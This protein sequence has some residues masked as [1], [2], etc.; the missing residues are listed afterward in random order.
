MSRRGDGLLRRQYLAA[1]RAGLSL[2][3]PVLRAGRSLA[4]NCFLSMSRRGDGLLR[5]QYLAA[6]RADLSVRQPVLRAGRCLAR[7]CFLGM[8]RRG[9]GL[10]RR[11]HLAAD[12]ADLS[13]RQSVLRAG[14]SLAGDCLLSV[15]HGRKPVFQHMPAL[16]AAVLRQSGLRA[17][18][19]HI[20]DPPGVML[21]ADIRVFRSVRGLRQFLCFRL[22]LR[23]QGISVFIEHID[24][25]ADPQRR[26]YGHLPG[27]QPGSGIGGVKPEPSVRRFLKA[28]MQHRRLRRS[29][30]ELTLSLHGRV[31]A[32]GQHRPVL[33]L[34]H[35]RD[36]LI[37][38]DQL[39]GHQN[40]G[41]VLRIT[42]GSVRF[43]ADRGAVQHP[44]CR[45]RIRR[46][47]Q[48]RLLL[49]QRGRID[50]NQHRLK[51][52]LL[53]LCER[54]GK[55]Q[56]NNCQ[57]NREC[58]LH[59]AFPPYHGRHVRVSA[60]TVPVDSFLRL[61]LLPDPFRQRESLRVNADDHKNDQG[62][63]RR[64]DEVCRQGPAGGC[65]SAGEQDRRAERHEHGAKYVSRFS[66]SPQSSYRTNQF[67]YA[68][69]D[70][71]R[72]SLVIISYLP[73]QKNPGGLNFPVGTD[74]PAE[75]V[76]VD[77]FFRFSPGLRNVKGLLRSGVPHER[78]GIPEAEQIQECVIK[79]ARAA[80]DVDPQ[81][82][83]RQ[84][85]VPGSLQDCRQHA[86]DDRKHAEGGQQGDQGSPAV[87]IDIRHAAVS[88]RRSNAEGE[89]PAGQ[90]L[91]GRA[92]RQLMQHQICQKPADKQQHAAHGRR[93]R[94]GFPRPEDQ[95]R[96]G[97]RHGQN[98]QAHEIQ[99]YAGFLVR[100][101]HGEYLPIPFGKLC[102]KM[103]HS[104]PPP[105][106]RFRYRIVLYKADRHRHSVPV[107]FSL[108]G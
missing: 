100:R 83:S 82:D 25:P 72:S 9:D 94:P 35:G 29:E 66:F 36:P 105:P 64:A 41:R 24:L 52:I 51:R 55:Q 80:A 76:H 20:A 79:V 37:G 45:L 3:Q 22:R 1:G 26:G 2:C 63:A 75:T 33:Q 49:R 10:L 53:R 93:M 11:Q 84:K 87:N 30:K 58:S 7:N 89:L 17:S 43:G 69:I 65:L 59:K 57:Q 77:G 107:L 18:G 23:R 88:D 70:L 104:V 98:G 39:R 96:G 54:Q 102:F 74:V 12:R 67:M 99:L 95:P 73:K 40:E 19:L 60:E 16:D 90:Q 27:D 97:H 92:V 21:G 103:L 5:R 62:I 61:F 85:L 34:G 78:A 14:R 15:P 8:S 108:S 68:Y 38:I 31:A 4:R 13:V 6:D 42:E 46:D 28:V 32:D 56:Q 81:G 50:G 44:G 86:E 91:V 101:V 47:Q 48:G 71:I 106:F